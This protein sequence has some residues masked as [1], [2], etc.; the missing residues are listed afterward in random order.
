MLIIIYL[1]VC[2]I[3]MLTTCLGFSAQTQKKVKTWLVISR[4]LYLLLLIIAG[5][6][7]F[8]LVTATPAMAIIKLLLTII[9]V[10]FI[11]AGFTQKQEQHIT[12]PLGT[13]TALLFIA[14]LTLNY[15]F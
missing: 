8:Y 4:T 3:L 10:F 15:Y 5:T 14:N 13:A 11:E 1:A 12:V 2:T 6:R 9:W 7:F